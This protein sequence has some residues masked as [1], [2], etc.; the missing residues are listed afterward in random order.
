MTSVGVDSEVPDPEGM[1]RGHNPS[2]VWAIKWG[3]LLYGRVH[4]VVAF[5]CRRVRCEQTSGFTIV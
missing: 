4:T 5:F 3:S 2:Q 1:I